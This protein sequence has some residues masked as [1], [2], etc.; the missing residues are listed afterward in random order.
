[1]K[2][3]SQNLLISNLFKF[4]CMKHFIT[5]WAFV[6]A[7]FLGVIA[8][9][10]QKSEIAVSKHQ[11]ITKQHKNSI[12]DLNYVTYKDS[13]ILIISRSIT[14]NGQIRRT[15]SLRNTT[16]R[17]TRLLSNASRLRHLSEA[18]QHRYIS[19]TRSQSNFAFNQEYYLYDLRKLLI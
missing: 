2:F 7:L 16:F 12:T 9:P 6:I 11:S 19:H 14:R 15:N 17:T 3:K 4:Y 8:A 5:F 10:I 1:M 13:K 18:E